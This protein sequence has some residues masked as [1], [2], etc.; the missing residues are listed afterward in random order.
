MSTDLNVSVGTVA[1][2]PLSLHDVL[3]GLHRHRHLLPLLKEAAA[4]RVLLQH[5]AREELSVSDTELQQAADQFRHRHGL[6]GAEQTHRWLA[7]EGL[8]IEDFEAGLERELLLAKL[9]QHLTGPQVANR[10][11]ARRDRYARAALRLIVVASEGIGR[12][13]LAQIIEEGQD[14]AAL[15]RKHSLHGP[16]RLAGGSLGVVAR[17]DLPADAADAVFAASPGNVVGPLPGPDGFRLILVEELLPPELD[18][19]TQEVIR[20]ELFDAWLNDRLRE[21]RIDVS[22]L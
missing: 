22:W 10:F 9:K 19:E 13:L 3:R 11:H 7:R 2:A 8:T 4:E 21:V 14:F 16:S 15:A 1:G 20:Q 5:A 12:E 17:Y 6:S 18:D